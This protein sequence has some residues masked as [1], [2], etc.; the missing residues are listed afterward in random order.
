MSTK[1]WDKPDGAPV[2]GTDAWFYDNDFG[3]EDGILGGMEVSRLCEKEN[4]GSRCFS[5]KKGQ[6]DYRNGY[7]IKGRD[8]PNPS[9]KFGFGRGG[10]GGAR[11][12]GGTVEEEG[13]AGAGTAVRG[14]TVGA[15]AAILSW[16]TCP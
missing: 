16:P 9:E 15:V 11:G 7:K 12:G 13:G 6:G 8:P 10:G 14:G 3:G 2:G 4:A 5:P 1:K